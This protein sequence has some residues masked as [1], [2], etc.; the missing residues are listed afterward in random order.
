M[1]LYATVIPYNTIESE[2]YSLS[3]EA[4]KVVVNSVEI[5]F[6]TLALNI[7]SSFIEGKESHLKVLSVALT[8]TLAENFFSYFLYF[9]MNATS[10]EFQWEFIQTS[11]ISNIDLVERIGIVALIECYV[12]LK[13]NEKF[14][15]HVILILLSKYTI[16]SVGSKYIPGL[17]EDGWKLIQVRIII[18]IVFS[19]LSKITFSN[20]INSVEADASSSKKNN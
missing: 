4:L 5:F 6:I 12:L 15:L 18:C 16:N 11:V 8:W 2:D 10:D 13:K 1:L 19:L 3:Q 14:N 17:N 20:V 9:V 7:K